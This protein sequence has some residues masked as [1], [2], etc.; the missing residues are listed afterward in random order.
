MAD[1]VV[2][3]SEFQL[4]DSP[5]ESL[6]LHVT[7]VDPVRGD[8]DDGLTLTDVVDRLRARCTGN[9]VALDR[10]DGLLAAAGYRQEDDYDD[11]RWSVTE[12]GIYRVES[13]FPRLIPSA[14]PNG[15][16]KIGYSVLLQECGDMLVTPATL[17]AALGG[18]NVNG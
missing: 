9:V 5:F 11:F 16:T 17:R 15:V 1:E 7:C 13:R 3:S 18:A 4:D 6:F 14:V 8:G 2:I 12:R 10:F